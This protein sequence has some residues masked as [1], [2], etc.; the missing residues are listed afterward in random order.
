[1]TA[2]RVSLR[3]TLRRVMS[4]FGQMVAA[5]SQKAAEEMSPG[6]VMSFAR[7]SAGPVVEMVRPFTVQGMLKWA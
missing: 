6:T 1:M 4:E 5:T 3:P 2:V 7:M